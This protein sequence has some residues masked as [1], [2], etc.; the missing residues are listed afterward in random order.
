MSGS[1]ESFIKDIRHYPNQISDPELHGYLSS[2]DIKILKDARILVRGSD[3]KEVPCPSCDENHWIET[4]MLDGQRYSQ[5]PMDSGPIPI[6]DSMVTVWV[7]QT[8]PFLALC[9]GRLKI[10]VG[11]EKLAVDGLWHVGVSIKNDVRHYFYY[12]QGKNP[13]AVIGHI[14]SLPRKDLRHI[15]FTSHPQEFEFKDNNNQILVI[16]ITEIVSLKNEKL[17]IDKEYLDTCL[18]HAFRTVDFDPS[19]G[20]L[21]VRGEPIAAITP[22]TAEYYFAKVLWENFNMPIS[23]T[24][25]ALYI[26]DNMGKSFA[27]TDSNLCY[28][29]KRAIKKLAT[30]QK[31]I[32]QIFEPTNT[33]DGENAFR[34]RDPIL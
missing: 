7:F 19:N 26:S 27:D 31:L 3:L 29:Q 11:V 28:K 4:Y 30:N 5:C 23:H 24:Q 9:G 1:F 34:M 10:T 33:L 21:C 2:D 16:A 6:T 25:I 8:E 14:Q 17:T 13:N 18:V 12:Y 22:T 15:V 20:D 32:E